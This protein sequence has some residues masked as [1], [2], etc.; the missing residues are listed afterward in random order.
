MKWNNIKT[1]IFKELR[2]IIRDKKSLHKLIIYPL[3]IPLII[4]VYIGN[5]ISKDKGPVF[6]IQKRIGVN[7]K[8]F[9]IYKFRTMVVGA[10]KKLRIYLKN[11]PE[12][13]KSI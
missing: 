4:L 6:Y 7:G 11:H 12:R 3:L 1:T 2:G 10:D 5:L 13:Q 9:K 8:L